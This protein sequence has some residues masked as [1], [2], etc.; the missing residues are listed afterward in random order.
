MIFL[1]TLL[2]SMFTNALVASSL[3]D[4][5]PTEEPTEYNAE[6]P[7]VEGINVSDS[8]FTGLE[9][10]MGAMFGVGTGTLTALTFVAVGATAGSVVPVIGTAIGA[11]VGFI[12]GCFIA[13]PSIE[14]SSGGEVGYAVDSFNNL[15]EI[16]FG[17]LRTLFDFMTFNIFRPVGFPIELTIALFLLALPVWIIVMM[18]LVTYSLEGLKLLRGVF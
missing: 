15:K 3:S 17:F 6:L 10:G 4:V 18:W 9:L 2:L 13:A 5:V 14:T 7:D 12:F 11:A 8:A 1:T 16:F